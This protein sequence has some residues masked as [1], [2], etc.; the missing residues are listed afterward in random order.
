MFRFGLNDRYLGRMPKVLTADFV[1]ASE[2]GEVE[3]FFAAHP[4]AG[5]GERARK[6]ALEQIRNNINW[7]SNHQTV[8]Q[9]WLLAWSQDKEI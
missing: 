3:A 5:A 6:Q 2:L 1:T 4:A 9:D 8:V 7:L